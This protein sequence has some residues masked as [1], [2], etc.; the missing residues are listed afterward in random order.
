MAQLEAADESSLQPHHVAVEAKARLGTM[1]SA[2]EATAALPLLRGQPLET[3][4]TLS[5]IL[6]AP[7]GRSKS[8][9][10]VVDSLRVA[11]LDLL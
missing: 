2:V 6:A 11:H 9:S 8:S 1:G 3:S 5:T 10:S 7:E 4:A